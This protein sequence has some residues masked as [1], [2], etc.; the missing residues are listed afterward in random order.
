ML[1][2]LLNV[3][4]AAALL[5][6]AVRMVRTGVERAFAVPLRRWLR[7]PA[8]NRIVAA[9]SGAVVAMMLQSATALAVMAA[10]FIASGAISATVGLAMLLGA[11]VGSALGSGPIDLLEAAVAA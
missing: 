6:Y 11:D 1:V 3:A 10:G 4:G 7:A 5:I 9:S 2:F 8:G